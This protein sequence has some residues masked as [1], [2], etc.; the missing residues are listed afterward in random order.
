MATTH[1]VGR[2]RDGPGGLCRG[3]L[4]AMLIVACVLGAGLAVAAPAGDQAAPAPTDTG[5]AA[6]F[7]LGPLSDYADMVTR[8]LFSP[9]RRPPASA[10]ANSR[11][12]YA[13]A[14]VQRGRFKLAGVVILGETRYALLKHESDQDF[15]RIEEGQTIHDWTVTAIRPGEVVL[16]RRGVRDIVEL[17]ANK[18]PALD[19]RKAARRKALAKSKI[20]KARRRAAQRQRDNYVRRL[21]P[22][23]IEQSRRLR[24]NSTVTPRPAPRS[25][26]A[27]NRA[28]ER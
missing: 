4:G 7:T 20:A 17:S 18:A 26:G 27:L 6:P 16:D 15:V 11:A 5:M 13:P 1:K 22:E 2:R 8:P 23:E 19:K 12:T 10:P 14:S 24:Q 25:R 28:E 3:A 9:Q 21:R